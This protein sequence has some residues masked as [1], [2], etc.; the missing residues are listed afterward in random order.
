MSE[1]IY[2]YDGNSDKNEDSNE[3]EDLNEDSNEEEQQV[4]DIEPNREIYIDDE[5]TEKHLGQVSELPREAEAGPEPDT[6][7]ISEGFTPQAIEETD[8]EET[9]GNPL[10]NGTIGETQIKP[11]V[12]NIDFDTHDL[13]LTE[14][15]HRNSRYNLRPRR[16]RDY[17]HLHVILESLV[18]TQYPMH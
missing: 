13:A 4:F 16:E 9:E 10:T 6:D 12:E 8:Y 5:E 11:Q 1:E 2:F 18:M 17:S 14:G 3:D 7:A 15:I